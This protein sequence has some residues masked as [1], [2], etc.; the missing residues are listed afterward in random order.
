MLRDITLGQYFPGDSVIHR[1]DPAVKILASVVYMVAVFL[2]RNIWSFAFILAASVFSTAVS[3][4]PFRAVL[5]SMKPLVIILLITTFINVF[6]YEGETVLVSWHFIHITLE[7]ILN[8]L[9]IAVRIIC[10]LIG[11]SVIL[12]YTTSPIDITDGIERLLKPLAMLGVD[13]H[14]FAMMM[15]IALRFIPTLIEET[16]RII[17]AQKARGAD[18]DSGNLVSRAKALIPVLIPLFAA[19]LRHALDLATAMECRCYHGGEGRTKMNERK[20]KA[21]DFVLLGAFV[22]IGAC[23]IIINKYA[24][25]FNTGSV[26][27]A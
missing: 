4:I 23:V 9:L 25:G 10:L 20:P 15:A 2:C 8:A 27:G 17:S 16:D 12:T 1:M 22:I 13:V 11:T 21:G 18:F 6:F 19:A 7:G 5:K 24:P 14:I 3:K 26:T